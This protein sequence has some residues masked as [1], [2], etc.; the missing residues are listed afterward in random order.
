MKNLILLTALSMMV[1]GLALAEKDETPNKVVT[2]V[3]PR[4][5][6]QE[7]S[8]FPT[9]VIRL[10]ILNITEKYWC[11]AYGIS[12]G[13]GGKAIQE[14]DCD[15]YSESTPRERE[16]YYV[17]S[18][19]YEYRRCVDDPTVV[20]YLMKYGEILYREEIPLVIRCLH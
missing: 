11:P 17:I 2:I 20:I 3:T 10:K 19:T 14:S 4:M 18:K 6:I 15:P 5:Q 13:D 1:C 7:G 8:K 12:F 9:I 16:R